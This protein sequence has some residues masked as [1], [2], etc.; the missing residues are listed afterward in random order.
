MPVPAAAAPLTI[1]VSLKMYFSHART[2]EWTAAVAEIARTH[3]AV[4]SGVVELVVI[5]TF[6]ALAPARD[7][8]GDAPVTL[9]A[10]DLAWAD[11]GAFTGEVSG[12]ELR[13]IGVDL[14]EIAHAERRS[15]FHETD[16]EIA[17]KV[18][19][20]FRNHLRPLICVGEVH[21]ASSADAV[22]DVTAQLDRFLATATADG[23]AGPVVAAY[24]PVWAIGAPAPAPDEH[25]VEVLAGIEE[26][27]ASRPE[28]AGSVA[29]YGGSAGPGLLTR[30][31]GRIG[32][33]FL[34]RFAH[35]P[36]A[37]RTILDEAEALQQTGTTA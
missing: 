36:E 30:G 10:Q 6:P 7:V 28:L 18:H 14:V 29:I 19:A 32:G 31:A 27:L 34:G 8:I 23:L 21:R 2:L 22:A 26:H 9:G 25:I 16:E 11:S 37:I 1:G 12:A 35:D 13:E 4:R 17:G 15:L 3:P 5:P 20:A 24:E 33:L